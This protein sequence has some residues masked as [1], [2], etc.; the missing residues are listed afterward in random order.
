MKNNVSKLHYKMYKSGKKWIVAGIVTAATTITITSIDSFDQISVNA[1]TTDVSSAISSSVSASNSVASQSDEKTSASSVNTNKSDSAQTISSSSDKATVSSSTSLEGSSTES[2]NSTASQ[3]IVNSSGSS[4]ISSI[5][6]LSSSSINSTVSSASTNSSVAKSADSNSSINKSNQSS[7][8]VNG[9]TNISNSSQNSSHSSGVAGSSSALNSSNQSASSTANSASGSIAPGVNNSG[10]SSQDASQSSSSISVSLS[11]SIADNASQTLKQHIKEI[12]GKYYYYTDDSSAAKSMLINDNGNYYYFDST[13]ALTATDPTFTGSQG[14]ITTGSSNAAYDS[15]S[16]NI[17]NVDGFLTPDSWYRPKEILKNGTD[18]QPSTENDYRP[19]LT[20][21]WPTKQAEVSYLNYMGQQGL[22]SNANFTNSNDQ[23]ALNEAAKTV[24]ANIESKISANNGDTSWL[25][26]TINSF[27]KTQDQWNINSEGYNINDGFQGGTLAYQ[28]SSQTPNNN[29]DYRL[30]NRTPSQ[31]DGKVNY[32]TSTYTG[33]EFLLG[34]D[35]D[36][37]NPVVQAENLNWLHYLM[38]F[39]SITQNDSN[40]NFDSIRVDAVENMDADM[41]NIAAQYFKD[42]YQTN[43]SEQNANNHL[44]ILEDW[45]PNDAQY[46]KDHGSN[47]LTIDGSFLSAIQSD[48]FKNPDQRT[49]LSSLINGLVNRANDNSENNAYPNYSIVRAHDNGVQDVIAQIV[50]DKIDPTSNGYI[51]TNDQLAQAFQIY[52]NDQKQAVKQYTQYN[53]PSAYALMLTNKDT[54]PR[55]YY[56]DMYTD[57]G[58]YMATKTPYFDAIDAMLKGRIKY[59]AGGQSMNVQYVNGATAA[60]DNGTNSVLT[61]VRYGQGATD[62]NSIGDS[63]TRTSGIAVIE[64]NNPQL[65]LADT[66]KIVV[67]MG[68]AHKN[69]AYRA[70]VDSNDAGLLTY[71]NDSI[72]NNVINTDDN[73]NLV[74]DSSVVKGYSNPQ[75]SGYLSMWVPVGA[76]DD[77]DVRTTA[78]DQK[79]NDGQTLHSNSALDSNVIYEGFSNFQAMPTKTDEYTNVVLAKNAQMFNDWGVTYMELPPQYRSTTD[80]SFLDS[81]IQNGYAFNDRYDLGFNTPTKYGTADQLADAIRSF[82]NS[83][84]K[85]IADYVPDQLYSLPNKQVV[86]VNRTNSLGQQITSSDIQNTLYDAYSKGSGTDYQAKYGGEFLAELQQKYPDLFTTQQISTGKT[87]DPSVKIKVWEA[88]YLNGTNLQGNGAG[89]VLSNA[90]N[91]DYFTVVGSDNQAITST[92]LPKQLSGEDVTYGLTTIDGNQRYVST[93]GYMAKNAFLQDDSGN[94]FYVDGN[95]DFVKTTK[96]INNN[97]YYFLTNGMNLRNFVLKSADGKLYYYQNNGS[98]AIASGYYTDTDTNKTVF[99]TTDGTLAQGILKNGQSEQYYNDEGDQVKGA[100]VNINGQ[101]FYFDPNYGNLVKN[102]FFSQGD[103]WYYAGADGQFVTGYQNIDGRQLYFD[104]NG[105]QVKDQIE[106][107]DNKLMYFDDSFGDLVKNGFFSHGTNWYYAGADGSLVN[108]Y[109]EINGRQ[110]YFNADGSQVKDQIETIDGKSMYFDNAQGDLVKNG[111]FSHGTN[112]YYAGADGSLVNGYQEIN[113]RQLYF[114]PDGSQVKDQ[115]ETVDGKFLYFDNAQGDLVKNGFFSHGTNWYYAGT[116]GNLVTGYQNING[117]QLYF[118]PDGSQVKDQIETVDGKLLYFDNA[119]GDL[120]KNGFFSQGDNWYYSGADGQLV[121]GYQDINGRKMY[122][123]ADGSQSKGKIITDGDGNKT[124][125]SPIDGSIVTNQDI[126]VDGLRYHADANGALLQTANDNQNDAAPDTDI[127]KINNEFTAH[128]QLFSIDKNS[129]TT[130]DGFLTAGT[131]YRPKDILQDGTNWTS[132]TSNDFRP[133]LMSWWPDKQTQVNYLNYMQN[134]GLGTSNYSINDSLDKLTQ[135]AHDVQA[136]IEQKITANN[137]DTNWLKTT[138]DSFINT[139]SAWNINSE[140]QGNDGL[141]GGSLTYNNN[142]LTPDANSDYRKLNQGDLYEFLLANDVDN[143]NPV[144]QAETLNWV[145]Y[146]MNI[147]TISKND[148][149]ANFDGI[150]IDA[151]GNVDVDA[152]NLI[153]QYMNDA[154]KVN[155]SDA[156]ANAHLSIVENGDHYFYKNQKQLFIDY[157]NRSALTNQPGSRDSLATLINNVSGLV[158]RSSDTTDN[159]A[160]PNYSFIH[161]HD[162]GVQNVLTQIVKDKINPSSDGV[163]ITK[164]EFDQALKY[165]AEDINSTDKQYTYYNVPAAYALILTN[166]DTVPRVYYGDM[167]NDGGQYMETKTPYYDS[168]ASMLEGRIKYVSGGQEMT[169]HDGGVLTSVRYGKDANTNTDMGDASTRT[170][171][172]A[173]V[174]SNNPNLQNVPVTVSMGAAHQNQAYRPL[175]LTND[176]GIQ[177]FDNDDDAQKYFVYTDA[178]G[179]LTLNADLIKGYSNP[180]VSGNLSV[181]V[182]VGASDDQDVR[183]APSTT[184]NTDGNVF[185]S[186][187]ALD[188]N[189]IFEAFSNFQ[190]MPQT[191]DQYMNVILAKM[192]PALKQLGYTSIELPP[193]YRSTTGNSFLDESVQNGYAFSD[194]YDLGYNTPTKYG[195]I[196]QLTELLKSLH[197]EGIQSMVDVVANQLYGLNTPQVVSATR[198]DGYG[199]GYP[200]W[201]NTVKNDLYYSNSIGGGAYQEK[202]GGEFLDQLQ[203]QYPDLFTTIQSSTGKTI[204]PSVKIKQWSAKYLNGSNLQGRGAGY[205]LRNAGNNQ[206]FMLGDQGINLPNQLLGKEVS[207][208][209]VNDNGNVSYYTLSGQK[210]VNSVI[211]I[212]NNFYAFDENGNL[213]VTLNSNN[214]FTYAYTPNGKLITDSFYKI[215]GNLYYFDNNGVMETNQFVPTD[216]TMA[217]WYYLGSDG[218]PV[219]GKQFSAGSYHYFDENGIQIKGQF[220]L[221]DNGTI[222]YYDPNLGNMMTNETTINGSNY[223]FNAD[224]TLWDPNNFIASPFNNKETYYLDANSH[225]TKG[226]STINGYKYYFDANGAML[227]NGSIKDGN[228]NLYQANENGILS[229][230]SEGTNGSGSSNSASNTNSNAD[231]SANSGSSNTASSGPASMSSNATSSNASSNASSSHSSSNASSSANNGSSSA[232]P[233]GSSSASSNAASSGS[234]NSGSNA[235]S[236]NSGSSNTSSSANNGSSSATPNGTSSASSNAASSGSSNSGSNASSTNSG[237]SNDSSSAN[238]GSSSA[239]PS[240]SSSASSNAASSGSSN[241]GSNSSSTNSGSG[242]ASSS[243]NS[244]GSS[245]TPSGTSSASSNVASSGSSNSGSNSSSDNSGSSNASSSANSNGSSANSGSSNASS[246]ANS[247]GSSANSGSSNASSSANSNGSSANNGSSN[248]S[249]SANSNGSSANSGS[250]NASSSSNSNGSSANSSSSNA[251][252]SANSNGSS[253]NSSSSNSSSSANSNGS[254]ANSGSSNASSSTNSNGSSANSGSSNASSSA[255]SNGSS[256][257]SGSSNASSSA[258]SN[259]SSANSGSSNAS[260]SANS[261]GSSSAT[262]SG[263]SSASSNS[264]SSGSSNASSSANSGS[265]SANNSNGSSASNGTSNNSS[266][267]SSISQSNNAASSNNSSNTA[268]TGTSTGGNASSSTNNY[269]NAGTGS[270]AVVD[271]TA[272]S[273]AF[274]TTGSSNSKAT[275]TNSSSASHANSAQSSSATPDRSKAAK[276]AAASKAHAKAVKKAKAKMDK[277]IKAMKAAKKALAKRQTKKNLAKYKQRLKTYYKHEKAYLNKNGQYSNKFYYDFNLPNKAKLAKTTF[278]YS[279]KSLNSDDKVSKLK[280]GTKIK[281]KQVVVDKQTT[282]FNLGQGKFIN[283]LKSMINKTK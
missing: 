153:S 6:T 268:N 258:N 239:T 125:Y 20:V 49:S 75:L 192:A 21:W 173:V 84:I 104:S 129:I 14:T 266:N 191:T 101:N 179:Q 249:S 1:E 216:S 19:L 248:A 86:S 278:V 12:D 250:S 207:T 38:N 69:Q 37:S 167:Y 61:S 96:T 188:S 32:T 4:N 190:A 232:T 140:G 62:E 65:K 111:F 201:P 142:G 60:T 203:K 267:A 103:N 189:V 51:L 82:H 136:K 119:Q 114:S 240:G 165:Y 105:V 273:S 195:T 243:A 102:G 235:S 138:M 143:S 247:N 208:G 270:N 144:V 10:H 54:V 110:L 187:A 131:W 158:D 272:N 34:N 117:R 30:L 3:S 264:A 139:Q 182:P 56:G 149:S 71:N 174:I 66:D 88:K 194:R 223:N 68:A 226:F 152:L 172:L 52:D 282:R 43:Q 24:Q 35:V 164:D 59:V 123:N 85:V 147:G 18:W 29:S 276:S 64:S 124:Y 277:S 198:T 45:S 220:V 150:R 245:A 184:T 23:D 178:N 214:R 256:A 263:S 233:S 222:S 209:F 98:K 132:S 106:T 221:N 215:N 148:P 122:F 230:L 196:D 137:G 180:Q 169:T 197:S 115:I 162:T 7:G 228:G 193:Q 280:A 185:H 251:N 25:K 252:S 205:V 47:Q 254:S 219:V 160:L 151:V 274:S 229:L 89:S 253:A 231:S 259:G 87:I 48:L 72:S 26:D 238:N 118:S 33:Y 255:N 170:S 265:S 141:Q 53:I 15:S 237:S 78:S 236:A 279:S 92:F 44:S 211:N 90:N 161:S 135:G 100:I 199:Y 133:L 17:T 218:T 126:D 93:S 77:Q 81:I 257:N 159:Q 9:S 241:S 95:G 181:W 57:D 70:L 13:G 206:Y 171:G 27:V 11:S 176:G 262:P 244:N 39:G 177:T 183:T 8:T 74:L 40:A 2:S 31:Q 108:G 155:Q 116:D 99:V 128:N 76:A 283:G 200:N 58:Q 94:W 97:G 112:W 202:F 227:V 225:I 127:T 55:V 212:D 80:N 145:H 271:S 50:K 281:I 121:T 269:V 16:N 46:L 79:I 42:A 246:S 224:G 134:N 67:N 261:N 28:N 130:T 91:S 217:H 36:N 113:G 234:S 163:H 22:I 175:M 109:Q 63:N 73:G 242:N 210:V 168:I 260:S 107:V 83:G 186:N 213:G 154:Y 120:V 156:D 5:A 157:T 275:S 204:D 146:L 166:K 41:L